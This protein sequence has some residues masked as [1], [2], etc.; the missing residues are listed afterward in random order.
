MDSDAIGALYL[1]T[2]RMLLDIAYACFGFRDKIF[3]RTSGRSAP[4]QE[5]KGSRVRKIVIAYDITT[6]CEYTPLAPF[7]SESY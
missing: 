6:C 5:K 4:A 2:M 7:A 1:E 3:L